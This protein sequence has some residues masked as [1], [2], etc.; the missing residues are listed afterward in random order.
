MKGIYYPVVLKN[1]QTKIFIDKNIEN[2]YKNLYNTI[3]K[4]L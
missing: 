2:D 4:E 3:A 1:I